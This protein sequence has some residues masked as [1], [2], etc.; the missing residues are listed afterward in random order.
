MHVL[1]AKALGLAIMLALMTVVWADAKKRED[2]S[3]VDRF[4]G[5]LFVVLAWTYAIAGDGPDGRRWLLPVLTTIWGVRLAGFITWRNW[6]HG[7]DKRYAAMRA[8][9]PE[10]FPNRSLVTVFW[11]QG[12]LAWTICA[13]LFYVHFLDGARDLWWL[14]FVGVAV[15]ALGLFYEAV[16][17]WQ[18]QRFL[19][20]PENRGKVMDRGLWRN[21]RHPNYFGDVTVWVGYALIATAGGAW[22]SWYG[23][24]LMALF[25]IKVSGVALTDKGMAKS[26]SKR[27]GYDEYV[28]RTNAFIPGPRRK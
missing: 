28:R 10:G 4:W 16:G 21:T 1:A 22:W 24:A 11:L 27:D 7:E 6:G 17:D 12:L 9:D 8:K 26:G 23:T 25:I 2:V 18:L 15:W 3:T 5:L 13:P 14:D 20:D 19:A